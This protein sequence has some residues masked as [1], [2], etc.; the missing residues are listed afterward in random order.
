M[1]LLQHTVPP[2]KT[3][4]ATMAPCSATAGGGEQPCSAPPETAMAFYGG[5]AHEAAHDDGITVGG[6]LMRRDS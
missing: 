3:M 5:K 1:Q 2:S 6:E 4:V